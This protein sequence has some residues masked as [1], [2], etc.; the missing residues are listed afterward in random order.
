MK[1][2]EEELDGEQGDEANNEDEDEDEEASPVDDYS[3][4][5]VYMG[6]DVLD[7]CLYVD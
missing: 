5:T 7:R 3:G 2:A 6:A 4:L 1:E